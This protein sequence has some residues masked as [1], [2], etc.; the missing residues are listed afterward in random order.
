MLKEIAGNLL[1]EKLREIAV[2]RSDSTKMSDPPENT[3]VQ[4]VLVTFF[5]AFGYKILQRS[6]NTM[7]QGRDSLRATDTVICSLLMEWYNLGV[8]LVSLLP[9]SPAVLLA[10][11]QWTFS[12]E[13][14][15]SRMKTT[16]PY[17][18]AGSLRGT[19][20]ASAYQQLAQWNTNI[21]LRI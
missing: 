2:D 16:S 21:F 8:V 17:G 12:D 10:D 7:S 6:T 5:V 19:C 18:Y 14:T 13:H 11:P 3:L 9:P 1:K 20:P 15:C 4:T